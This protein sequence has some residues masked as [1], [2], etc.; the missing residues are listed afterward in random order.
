[1]KKYNIFC[2]EH[3]P[4]ENKGEEAIIRGMADVLFPEGNVEFHILDINAKEYH[5]VDGLHV[6]PGEWFY[7]QWRSKE[8]G[9]GFSMQK[10]YSS[11][12]SLLRN[13][14]NV[15]FPG[16]VRK[17]QF[18]LRS[19]DNVF[20]SIKNDRAGSTN[21]ERFLSQILECDYLIA[22][23]DGAFDEYDCHVIKLMQKHGMKFG[24]FGTSLK[25]NVKSQVI[26]D[27]FKNTLLDSDFT[28][29]RNQ[30]AI[31][32]GER[33]FGGQVSLTLTPDPAFGMK[34]AGPEVGARIVEKEGLLEFFKKPVIMATTCEPAPIARHCF[35]NSPNP[36]KKIKEHRRFLAGF[37][38]H[39]VDVYN[40]NLL[41]L[42]HAIGPG[43]DLDDR[44]VAQDILERT[45]L[46]PERARVLESEYSAKEL[47][48]LIREAD[49]LVAERIHSMI[50]AVGVHTPFLCLGSKTDARVRGI[51]GNMLE[52]QDLIYFLNDPDIDELKK[53]FDN[54]WGN[55]KD[56]KERF[57]RLNSLFLEKLDAASKHIRSFII[58]G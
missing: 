43:P 1:M 15:V 42:P 51:I 36:G 18:S 8:F 44:I 55:R 27:I 4:L 10:V 45:G 38:K 17:P 32:W 33:V 34:A 58:C 23:H 49:L 19:A 11:A 30:I 7:S 54:V 21:K 2:P 3:V 13:G 6:Y 20:S 47:K 29:C 28:F 56:V 53:Q 39:V 24:V 46:N 48:A 26:I 31:D 40:V 50:G 57:E 25:P 41:F 14:L 52:S 16:W 5:F 12:C 37:F 9:L 22:G 35:K